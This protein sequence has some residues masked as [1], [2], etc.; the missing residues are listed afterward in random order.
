M[1]PRTKDTGFALVAALSML[2]VLAALL[3]AYFVLTRTELASV[4]ASRDATTG[5][6]AAEAGLNLR[7]EGI[8]R[9]FVGFNQPSGTSTA[10][11]CAT[12]LGGGDY[13][14]RRYEF[15]GRAVTTYVV[16]PPG[17]PKL[18]TVPGGEPFANLSAQEYRYDLNSAATNARGE[19]EAV[20]RMRF[21]SRLVPLFQFAAFYN[22]DLEILPDPAMDLRGPVHSNGDLY[23]D[24][25]T[26][27][28]LRGP[29][30]AAGQLYR[31][32]KNANACLGL[33]VRIADPERQSELPSCLSG[34]R[35]ITASELRAW[36]DNVQTGTD[37]VTVPGPDELDPLPGRLYWD[38]ADLRI[39][40]NLNTSPWSVELRRP[41]GMLDFALTDALRACAAASPARP[42]VS[43]SNS[44]YNNRENRSRGTTEPTAMLEVDV[45]RLMACA[46]GRGLLGP[47]KRLDDATDGGLVWHLSVDGPSSRGINSYG[48]RL[49]N[50]S[51]LGA[52]GAPQVK[53][54]TVV[55]DQAVYLRGD[56]NTTDKAPAAVMADSI[57]VLSN[58]WTADA[59]PG[60]PL[61]KA[62]ETTVNAA[63][64]AGTD[65][66]GG[67]DGRAGQDRD[68]ATGGAT[69]NGGLENYPRLHEDWDGRT[70]RYRGS[71]VS[72]FAPRR[73]NGSWSLQTYVPPVRDWQYD[74]SFNVARQLPPLTPR[75]V[76]L[77][78][79]LFTRQFDR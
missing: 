65:A 4:A 2:V 49:S 78:Q 77:K 46:D 23:L 76:Y 41:D 31:G 10:D 57:N 37:A 62:A 67:A 35:E 45:A 33:P 64:L 17:N 75:A 16:E 42:P 72:L 58:A 1:S 53:G 70:L 7:A 24:A 51:R 12:T 74:T 3:S 59:R 29:V 50:A 18:T 36:N 39:A 60:D 21:R 14:C 66:T 34:R 28:D 38:R 5:Y 6:Y 40:L 48:V 13:A 20:L 30:S 43:F 73:A 19:T 15:Q 44:F 56:Y 9:V 69:Y 68:A 27:L 52:P 8:R 54:L 47:G 79:D 63:F 71:F 11:A 61:P 25:K 55:S 22:K 32:R 26:S